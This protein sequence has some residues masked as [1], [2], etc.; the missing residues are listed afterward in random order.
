MSKLKEIKNMISKI[1][2]LFKRHNFRLSDILWNHF[3]FRYRKV[4]VGKSC[5]IIGKLELQGHG[6]ILIGNN[7]TIFSRWNVNPVGGGALAGLS[8]GQLI[9]DQ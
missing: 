8:Y 2:A 7:V 4:N 1:K 3:Q 9:T 5:K 6:R